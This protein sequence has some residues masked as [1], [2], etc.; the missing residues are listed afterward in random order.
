LRGKCPKCGGELDTD[1]YSTC[2]K[3]RARDS[4]WRKKKW[5]EFSDK[6]ICGICHKK[7]S[8]PGLKMC[9]DCRDKK[10]QHTRR[11]YDW[12]AES[13]IC[14]RCRKETA[15]PNK[16]MCGE[17]AAYMAEHQFGKPYNKEKHNDTAK[18]RYWYRKEHGLCTKCGRKRN[19]SKSTSLCNECH[20]KQ[21]KQKHE[22]YWSKVDM[23]R[24]DRSM[25]GKCFIC[26]NAYKSKK[27]KVCEDCRK[28][29]KENASKQDKTNYQKWHREEMKV[30]F[31]KENDGT[32]NAV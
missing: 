19:N 16:T 21:L 1:L 4:D 25:F 9:P 18:K 7:E 11:I 30:I 27:Y 2:S 12:Y 6:G 22:K 20:Q 5:K 3:C 17:C 13:G 15:L 31:R 32:I 8:I 24:K 29:L 28:R 26:G 14:V 10:N 23:A